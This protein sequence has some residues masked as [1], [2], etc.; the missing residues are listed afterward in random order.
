MAK[1]SV[2]QGFMTHI[3]IWFI[4]VIVSIS[5]IFDWSYIVIYLVSINIVTFF[6]FAYDK[7]IAKDRK[8]KNYRVPEET[9]HLLEWIGATP[10]SLLGQ[11]L[12][13]HKTSKQSYK[14]EFIGIFFFQGLIVIIYWLIV[15]FF[16]NSPENNK[17]NIQLNNKK[18][19]G[20][21]KRLKKDE[22]LLKIKQSN[23]SWFEN[24]FNDTDEVDKLEKEIS[25]IKSKIEDLKDENEDLR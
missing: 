3:F 8:N 18:I 1:G 4:I 13:T 16:F 2:H 21:E 15:T 24:T 22:Y 5:M 12:F 14:E 6:T 23:Q 9:L 19:S 7:D 10:A 17:F 11:Y 20:Y 25:E